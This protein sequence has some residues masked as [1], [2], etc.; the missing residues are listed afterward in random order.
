[1]LDEHLADH[2]VID[3]Q[4]S[5]DD[6]HG[7]QVVDE[8][9]G[10]FDDGVVDERFVWLILIRV[11]IKH[12][13]HFIIHLLAYTIHGNCWWIYWEFF[14]IFLRIFLEFFRIFCKL[15][16]F[17]IIFLEFFKIFFNFYFKKSFLFFSKKKE[18]KK[19]KWGQLTCD[20]G[21]FDRAIVGHGDDEA[22]GQLMAVETLRDKVSEQHLASEFSVD[23]ERIGRV[24]RPKVKEGAVLGHEERIPHHLVTCVR[25]V[26]FNLL[27]FLKWNF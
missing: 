11:L 26:H 8:D 5:V 23:Y 2:V 21:D 18:K 7:A 25:K 20:P 12:G 14:R 9:V 17:R 15:I 1:M 6:E 16:F 19:V 24:L 13:I 3:A 4:H 22:V 10:F 27:R